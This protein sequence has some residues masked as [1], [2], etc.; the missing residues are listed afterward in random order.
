MFRK[1][2]VTA[3]LAFVVVTLPACW[4]LTKSEQSA[5]T[6]AKQSLYVINVLDRDLYND[7]HIAGSVQVSLDAIESFVKNLDKNVEIVVYCSGYSCLASSQV[8]QQLK[9]LGFDHV[10]AYEAGMADWHQ[11]ASATPAK[12]PTVGACT[13]SYLKMA[14]EKPTHEESSS[15]AFIDT[16]ELRE[17]MI[18][19]GLIPASAE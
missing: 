19:H 2:S 15:A 11:K 9:T 4:P 3:L 18:V 8:A 17:K 7:C 16:D 6:V 10:W 14:N 12:Y 13:K 1:I 5:Q